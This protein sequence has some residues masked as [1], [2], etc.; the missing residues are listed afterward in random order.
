V[1][2]DWIDDVREGEGGALGRVIL[3]AGTLVKDNKY[4]GDR[5]VAYWVAHIAAQL[6]AGA[7]TTVIVSK[8]GVVEF[9]PVAPEIARPWL[10]ALLA[11]WDEGGRRPLPLAVK[12]AFAWLRKLPVDFDPASSMVPPQAWD[13]ARTAYEGAARLAGERDTNPYLRRAFADFDRLVDGGE[14]VALATSL[15]LPVQRAPLASSK[16]G[17]VA[18]DVADTAG[19]AE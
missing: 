6:A 3:D 19:E 14:F 13:A 10:L 9:A 12:T 15:L 7:V 1:L 4:R 17:R 11:A 5:L 2:Q 8:V 16:P 18:P